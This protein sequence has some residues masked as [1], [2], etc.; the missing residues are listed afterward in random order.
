LIVVAAAPLLLASGCRA[1]K[2]DETPPPVV[3]VDVAPVLNASIQRVIRG[4]AV[5]YPLQQAAIVAKISAPVKKVYVERG[6]RV[7]A[8]QLLMELENQ[9]LA[10]AEQESR[11]ALDLAEATYQT[12]ARGTVPQ[13]VQKAE[14]E[15]RSARDALAA[16]QALY[17]NRQR[18]FTEG[19]IA[20][21]DVN[22]AQVAL[23]QARTQEEMARK[24]LEDMQGFA[25]DQALK[26]ATAQLDAAKSRHDAAAA[27]LGYSRITS[28][29]DGVVT[30]RTLYAGES[31][32]SGSPLVTVMDLSR[33]IARA[34]VS[35]GEAGE[36]AVGAEAGIIGPDGAPIPGKVT[37][38]SPALD[39]NS[40]TVEVWVE[41]DNR[42]GR[43]R[44][45]SNQRVEIVARTVPNALVIPEA[46]VL[47]SSQGTTTVMVIDENNKPHKDPVA[48]GIRDNGRVE[49]KTGLQ[50]GQ[51]V[52]TTGAFELAKLEE[53][54]LDRTTVKIQAPKEEEEK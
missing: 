6:A 22:D 33:V 30:E 1:A 2:Q 43:L 23:S 24:R 21:K 34:H 32:A 36:I 20:Q 37:Q 48:L 25:K 35:Q 17:D 26:A 53:D 47:T 13:D 38:I 14:L 16:A 44:P 40:T 10:A 9:D 7:R 50:S 51:R 3:T 41:V 45:G 27:Q 54:V 5:L 4:D 8:G 28:P 52:A 29:I 18:L 19:A 49:V 46:A 42:D 15:Q 12:T 31:A 11:A 39:P